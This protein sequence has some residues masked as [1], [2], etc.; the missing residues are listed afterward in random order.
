MEIKKLEN[1]SVEL[2]LT[3]EAKRIEDE[4]GKALKDYAK[5]LTM[6]GFR[7]GKAPVS[8]IE[9]KYGDA[10]REEI[11][12]RLMEDNLK[13]SYKDMDAKD[14]PLPYSTPE[15]QNEESLL[16]F[17]PNTDITYSVIYDV[18]PEVKFP[19]YKGQ[20]FEY[21]DVKVTDEQVDAEIERLRQQNAMVIAKDGK[22]VEG[23]IVT[24]DYVEL[25]AEGNEVSSTKRDDFTF[26]VGSSYNFYK[27]DNDIV[28]LAKGDEKVIEK[29]YGD[30]S[31]MG[32]DYLGKTI[33]VKVAIKEVKVRQLPDVDDEFA[34]DVK[35]EYKTV[36]DLKDATRKSLEQNAE[37]ENKGRK[38]ESALEALLAKTTIAVPKSMI[39][40][41]L[42]QDWR[43]LV[44]RFG[45]PEEE[46]EKFMRANGGGK[47]EFLDTRRADTE[48][49]IKVQLILEQVKEEQ[50]FTV[51]DEELENELK[52][53]AQDMTKD[54][55]NYDAFKMYAED[56]IKFAKARDYILEN[57]TF[58]AVE[59][60]ADAAEAKTEEAAPKA[61]KT[62]KKKADKAEN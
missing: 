32:T 28:G 25:D 4:Y 24:M 58:K 62:T 61:K 48:H 29:T 20:E 33:K 52:K 11:T 44:Q 45:M 27:L 19:E 10:I 57:N 26:T 23:D 41:Q 18:L 35:E 55:P 2:T 14:R 36:K 3:L 9:N 38:L 30:D 12:F 40:A 21:E 16:P 59:K 34:Q 51:S 1:S 47:Q 7:P 22:I 60:K 8:L 37:E 39:E 6:K 46:V 31:G 5:K 17:K 50:N 43:N 54:N 53:Y 42:E 56:D 15:L 49:S 13:D